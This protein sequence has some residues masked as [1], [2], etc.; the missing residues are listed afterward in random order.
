MT[1]IEIVSYLNNLTD[2]VRL[3]LTQQLI[4]EST[5]DIMLFSGHTLGFVNDIE[6]LRTQIKN[7][8]VEVILELRSINS[9][10]FGNCLYRVS[11]GNLFSLNTNQ[12]FATS[13]EIEGNY[14][15]ARRL[16]YEFQSHRILTIKGYKFL[17]LQCGELNILKNIQ[18]DNNRVEFR[19]SDD[20]QL[21]EKF[22]QII[23]ETNIFLN[24]IH[25]PMANQGKMQ[26]RREY[27]TINKR[28]YFSTSNTKEDSDN[29]SLRSLQYAFYNGLRLKQINSKMT[30]NSISR[31][32]EIK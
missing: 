21:T 11:K 15:L 13:R 22:E 6:E 30:T 3:D 14:E 25:S 28:Y 17:T 29:L 10:K 12:L 23:K 26:K 16:I 2:K 4:N 20:L 5:S 9:D 32:F 24:P 19:L 18:S 8:R 27:L 7:K 1:T 31:I